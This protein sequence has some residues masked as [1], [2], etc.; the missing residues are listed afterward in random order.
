VLIRLRPALPLAASMM[1]NPL[2]GTWTFCCSPCSDIFVIANPHGQ[3]RPA[4]CLLQPQAREGQTHTTIQTFAQPMK[5]SSIASDGRCF[6][7]R[8][9]GAVSL[10]LMTSDGHHASVSHVNA[11]LPSS[12]RAYHCLCPDL[13]HVQRD[14][15]RDSR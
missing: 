13:T 11:V 2:D 12:I 14:G 7:F 3:G 5:Q 9:F 8:V 6:T 4:R 1:L 15:Y 10:G